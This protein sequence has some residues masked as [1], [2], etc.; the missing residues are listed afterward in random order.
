[1]QK[2]KN[3]ILEAVSNGLA[4]WDVPVSFQSDIEIALKALAYNRRHD[5]TITDLGH[6]VTINKSF[7]ISAVN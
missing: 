7:A 4:H 5:I 2:D 3:T 6:S 1:M